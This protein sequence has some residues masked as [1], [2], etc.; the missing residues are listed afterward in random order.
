MTAS[1]TTPAP[2]ATAT[3]LDEMHEFLS[4]FV[5]A[6][7]AQLAA[8][9]LWVGHAHVLDAFRTTPRLLITSDAP[10]CGKSEALRR[11]ADLVPR[12]WSAGRAT[13]AAVTAK[14]NVGRDAKPALFIDE[15][16]QVFGRAG[17]NGSQHP[18]YGVLCEGYK[19]PST[20]SFSAGRT[21]VEVDIFTAVAMAGRGNAVPDDVGERSIRIRMQPG[22]P[23]AD[24]TLREHDPQ[25]VMYRAAVGRYLRSRI[26]Q[27][28]AYSA[29][30]LHPRLTGRT[31]EIWEPLFAVADAAGGTWPQR[32]LD[33]FSDLVMD[34]GTSVIYTPHQLIL[35]DMLR[36]AE[37]IGTEEI[38]GLDIIAR[39]LTYG[40]A[41]YTSM[42]RPA[43]AKLMA[44]AMEPVQPVQLPRSADDDGRQR[45]GYY[46]ADI[47]DIAAAR[48]PADT[49]QEDEPADETEAEEE[50]TIF[51]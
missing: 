48:I 36:A 31:R 1:D 2:V 37:E 38:A 19:N 28:A 20:E 23:A 17:H 14:L 46:L 7:P 30:G 50:E 32:C 24:Y 3:P 4:Q 5:A 34:R 44:R 29:K 11:A 15:V 33:A 42:S 9:T 12:G 18:L 51:G 43:L 26:G 40:E 41:L 47:R 13:K 49:E 6:T 35:R 16:S 25:S 27:I 21:A 39:L 22:T 10:G 8:L 45:R